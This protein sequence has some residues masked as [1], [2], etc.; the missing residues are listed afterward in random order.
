VVRLADAVAHE[1]GVGYLPG[2]SP[3][4]PVL[5]QDLQALGLDDA[6]WSVTRDALM[7]T[8]DE[9]VAALGNLSA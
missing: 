5:P 1:K 2:R 8:I 7:V 9:A 4:Q 6:T 3:V